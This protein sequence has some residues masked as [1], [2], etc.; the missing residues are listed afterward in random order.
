MPREVQA[1]A[2]WGPRSGRPTCGRDLLFFAT[3]GRDAS[4]VA[5]AI[6]ALQ[7]VHAPNSDGVVR[8]EGAE[9]RLLELA[10]SR[11]APGHHRTLLNRPRQEAP[12]LEVPL[13]AFCRWRAPAGARSDAR[14]VL[15]GQ[16]LPG[17][18]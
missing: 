2:A 13:G 6:S 8:V 3:E 10:L 5:I 16:R 14:P 12:R 1:H 11:R 7:F 17:E 9:R 15:H 4:H 18:R